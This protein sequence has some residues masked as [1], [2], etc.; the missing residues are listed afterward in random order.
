MN[1][2]GFIAN[3]LNKIGIPYEFMRW[4]SDVQYPYFIGEYNE[5]PTMNEDGYKESSFI[6]TGTTRG[7]W[8]EL[9]ECKDAIEQ[10]FPPAGGLRGQTDRG[11]IVIF[12]SNAMPV[13]TGEAELKRIQINLDIKEWRNV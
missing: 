3:E 4:T 12:Y 1:A 10:C 13:P 5:I 8:L 9:E 7:S 6:L 2:L 11:S